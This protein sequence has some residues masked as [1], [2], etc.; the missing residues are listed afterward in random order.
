MSYTFT[1]SIRLP[2]TYTGLTLGGQLIDESS[3]PVGSK[4]SS[5]F[6]EIGNGNYILTTDIPDG[7]RGG[8]VITDESDG[9]I[10]GVGGI[11]DTVLDSDT[12]VDIANQVLMT[13]GGTGQYNVTI[14]V[15]DDTGTPI[16]E[17]PFRVHTS[18]G[19]LIALWRTNASGN[20]NLLLDS[21]EYHIWFTSSGRYAPANPY[22]VTVMKSYTFPPLII[23]RTITPPPP[24]DP[25]LCICWIDLRYIAGEHAGDLVGTKEGWI[26]VREVIDKGIIWPDSELYAAGAISNARIFSSNVGR[27]QFSALRGATLKLDVVRPWGE[28]GA[29]RTDTIEITVPDDDTY[30][31]PLGLYSEPSP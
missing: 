3:N 11:N 21:G 8:V 9:H 5:G 12:V 4:I 27:I 24:T 31:I 30:Y 2:E 17:L 14:P 23:P 1:F 26:D 25:T 18:L 22:L 6:F 16:A 13:F 15:H 28:R 29:R 20:I 7:H 10:L 19:A